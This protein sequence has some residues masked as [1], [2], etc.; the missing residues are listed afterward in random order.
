[1]KQE[2][3][4]S[5]IEDET[6]S[7]DIP[8][9]GFSVNVPRLYCET[10]GAP[11]ER[12]VMQYCLDRKNWRREQLIGLA[13]RLEDLLESSSLTEVECRCRKAALEM[14]EVDDLTVWTPLDAERV[15]G[16][17]S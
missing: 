7:Q 3:P 5:L 1:M 2:T 15:S 6:F 8:T 16:E 14:L 17:L 13:R 12:S 9:G 10:I 4:P 11:I